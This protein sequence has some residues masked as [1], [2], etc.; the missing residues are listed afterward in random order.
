MIQADPRAMFVQQMHALLANEYAQS[1][2]HLMLD[3][4]SDVH[5]ERFPLADKKLWDILFSMFSGHPSYRHIKTFCSKMVLLHTM[6]CKLTILDQ[7][8]SILLLLML[9]RSLPVS[10]TPVKD[11]DAI[12]TNA[13]VCHH[14]CQT[15]CLSQRLSKVW[16]LID[17]ASCEHKL[18]AGVMTNSQ[19]L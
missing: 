13:T 4:M 10:P 19:T 14:A 7:T 11:V 8:Q 5:I 12:L 9:D 15:P 1:C 18:V 3:G 6:I 16:I 2:P 17:E